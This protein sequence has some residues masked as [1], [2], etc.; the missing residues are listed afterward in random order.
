MENT[1]PE[2]YT[3]VSNFTVHVRRGR[4]DVQDPGW[5]SHLNW[6]GDRLY[7][8]CQ[9]RADEGL[10]LDPQDLWPPATP[11]IFLSSAMKLL[12]SS[13]NY[14]LGI[15]RSNI[16]RLA[17]KAGIPTR[18]CNF[19]LTQVYGAD[20][21]CTGTYSGIIPVR[22]VDGRAL[23]APLPGAITA[24]VQDLYRQEIQSI[25]RGIDDPSHR[26]VVR[27]PKYFDRLDAK[28]GKP[29]RLCGR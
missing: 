10:M 27:T 9:S 15:T 19:S 22:E 1:G 20:E 24:K 6:L 3:W 7:P 26:Y 2:V 18:E 25:A 21:V 29:G 13:G 17:Q 23:D 16:L 28:L 12:T 11:R 5:N 14:C 8:G 4:P